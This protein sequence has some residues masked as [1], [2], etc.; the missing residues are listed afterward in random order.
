MDMCKDGLEILKYL[1][2][3]N[4]YNNYYRLY[5]GF[6]YIYE[7]HHK[8]KQANESYLEGLEKQVYKVDVLKKLYKGFESRMHSRIDREIENSVFSKESIDA[9]IA[10][11]VKKVFYI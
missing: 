1:K 10:N 3:N 8:F 5:D 2:S 11:E 4:F 6:A 9:Y 7:H